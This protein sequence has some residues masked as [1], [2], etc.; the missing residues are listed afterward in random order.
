LEFGDGREVDVIY[1]STI[2]KLHASN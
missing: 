1:L 2:S